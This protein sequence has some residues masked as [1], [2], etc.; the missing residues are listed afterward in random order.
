M[1]PA[2]PKR[3]PHDTPK[4][5]DWADHFAECALLLT[6][7]SRIGGLETGRTYTVTAQARDNGINWSPVSEPVTFTTAA[8]NGDVTPPSVP[9]GFYAFNPGDGSTEIDAFWNASTDDRT[10]QSLI[11]YEVYFN[12]EFADGTM[13]RTRSVMY[14]VNGTNTVE[15]IAIDAA[16]NRSAAATTIVEVP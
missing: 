1:R 8:T 11:V 2:S 12:G 15:V 4:P 3:F 14:G 10:P 5:A 6:A 7:Q 13:G 16:G 9:P